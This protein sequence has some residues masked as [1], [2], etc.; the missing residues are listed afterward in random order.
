MQL[1]DFFEE[2][3]K[4]SGYKQALE[5]KSKLQAKMRTHHSSTVL[6]FRVAYQA[7]KVKEDVYD[8]FDSCGAAIEGEK[9]M[10]QPTIWSFMDLTSGPLGPCGQPEVQLIAS[11]NQVAGGRGLHSRPVTGS[12]REVG[13]NRE[14]KESRWEEAGVDD[15]EGWPKG[16]D[17]VQ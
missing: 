5:F 17:E 11:S 2:F 1:D 14:G 6:L 3:E 13:E 12:H 8:I 4:L 10:I 15:R 9:T 7:I 16:K